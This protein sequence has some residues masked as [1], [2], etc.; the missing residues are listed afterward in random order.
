MWIETEEIKYFPFK[1]IVYSIK[2]VFPSS[3]TQMCYTFLI[4]PK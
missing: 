3:T 2:R 1:I 4:L